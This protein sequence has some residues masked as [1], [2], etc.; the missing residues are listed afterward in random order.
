MGLFCTISAGNRKKI[1]PD[2]LKKGDK[3]AIIT[4]SSATD[5]LS[6]LAGDSVLRAWGLQPVIGPNA[7]KEYYGFGGTIEQRKSDLLWALSDSSIKAILC[8]RGGY[9]AIHLLNGLPLKTLKNNPKWLIGYSDIT[10][11]L[12]AQASAGVMSIHANMCAPFKLR[13]C[14]MDTINNALKMLLFGK[15]PHYEILPHEFN[16]EGKA[17]GVLIG[18]NMAVY[19]DLADTDYDFLREKNMILFIEDVGESISRVDQ[20][21]HRLEIRGLLTKLKAII[22]GD[23]ID[24]KPINGYQSMYEMIHSYLKKYPTLP[25]CYNFPVGHDDYNNFPMIVGSRVVLNITKEKVI[26]DFKL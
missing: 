15:L 2:F 3:V 25:V 7:F 22:V 23:F 8:S 12:S 26:L 21:L 19:G 6:V 17:E 13:G 1:Q 18:G 20:M 24:Y 5:S 11:L 16:V 14:Q 4:P 10:A 9:G